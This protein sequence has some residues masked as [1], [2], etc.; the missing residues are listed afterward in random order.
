M[1]RLGTRRERKEERSVMSG[2]VEDR[3]EPMSEKSAD[4]E[5]W[6]P[7]EGARRAQLSETVLWVQNS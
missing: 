1:P 5:T 3:R 4:R 7:C 2:E 6:L